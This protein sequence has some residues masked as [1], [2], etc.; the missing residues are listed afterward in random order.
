MMKIES[1]FAVFVVG[2]TT[3]LIESRVELAAVV[4]SRPDRPALHSA[5]ELSGVVG[6][7]VR[8]RLGRG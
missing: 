2:T 6:A 5:L 4:R 1:F 7:R 3:I 8:Q